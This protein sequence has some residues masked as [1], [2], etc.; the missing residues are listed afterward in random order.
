MSGDSAN[1]LLEQPR[2]SLPPFKVWGT[3]E[4]RAV[5]EIRDVEAGL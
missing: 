5:I 1:E 3:P 2:R 4:E